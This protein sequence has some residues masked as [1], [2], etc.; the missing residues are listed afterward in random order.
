[1]TPGEIKA[2]VIGVVLLAVFSAGMGA[3]G[4]AVYSW[5]S[6]RLELAQ[7]RVKELGDKITEQ[8]TAIEGLKAA[9][10]TR[11]AAAA[12]ALKVAK[13][14]A[15]AAQADV[16]NLMATQAPAGVDRCVAASDLIRKELAK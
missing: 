16:D 3:G 13:N 4:Y 11:A 9:A 6:P 5:Y 15:A 12:A 10:D 1:M 14:K 8:N 2:I 7:E